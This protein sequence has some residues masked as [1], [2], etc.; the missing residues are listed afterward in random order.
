MINYKIKLR[1]NK[2]INLSLWIRLWMILILLMESLKDKHIP[3][4]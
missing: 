4:I 2:I 3:H 1:Y